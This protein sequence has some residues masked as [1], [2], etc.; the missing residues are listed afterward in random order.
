[1][2]L[3]HNFLNCKTSRKA[4]GGINSRSYGQYPRHGLYWTGINGVGR[5]NAACRVIA[6]I[7]RLKTCANLNGIEFTSAIHVRFSTGGNVRNRK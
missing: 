4:S 6:D 3:R 7:R 2:A 5:E 1:M